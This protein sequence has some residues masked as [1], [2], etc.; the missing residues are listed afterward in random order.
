MTRKDRLTAGQCR[1]RFPGVDVLTGDYLQL[2]SLADQGQG[3]HATQHAT[4]EKAQWHNGDSTGTTGTGMDKAGK[5]VANKEEGETVSKQV[6]V[7]LGQ[8]Q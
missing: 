7:R 2:R 3:K 5:E 6:M 8:E 4:L 1:V